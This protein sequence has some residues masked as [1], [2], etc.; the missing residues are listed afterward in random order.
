MA[1]T[2]TVTD[3]DL[4][5][6]LIYAF[7]TVAFS[8][9]YTNGTGDT[10]NWLSINEQLGFSGQLVAASMANPAFGPTQASF[11][12]QGGTPNQYNLSQ[13]TTSSNWV[14]RGYAAGGTEF[15]T[16]SYPSSATGDKVIFAAQFRRLT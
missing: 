12:V 1:I 11:C 6:T 3:I 14:M 13:G 16:G 8:G 7:G 10:V 4:G 5:T 15:S 9:T 2:L